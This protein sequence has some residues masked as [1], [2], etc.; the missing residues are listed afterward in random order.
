MTI[1]TM[2]SRTFMRQKIKVMEE[3]VN[4]LKIESEKEKPK[5]YAEYCE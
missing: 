4:A 3:K 2:R 1:V 5:T